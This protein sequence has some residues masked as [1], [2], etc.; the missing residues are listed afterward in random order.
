MNASYF[1]HKLIFTQPAKTS[2]ETLRVR[3]V[4]IIKLEEDGVV[5]MGE[6]A[7]LFGLSKETKQQVIDAL[8]DICSNPAH[9]IEH[10]SE[11]NELPSVKFALESAWLDLQN[12]GKQIYFKS[13]FTESNCSIPING[14]VW[15]GDIEH[16]KNQIED[17]ISRGFACIKLKIGSHNFE[18]ELSIIKQVRK[19]Y[20][21]EQIT[22]RVDANGA[23]AFD[24]AQGKLEQLAKLK[25]HSIEQPIAA[26][27]WSKLSKLC[28]SSPLPIALDEELIGIHKLEDKC[29]LLDLVS[30]QYLILKP[31][32]H[33]G[34]SG[35]DEWISLAEER[36][37]RW[38]VTSYLES[39]I[40][41][42]AIAQWVATKKVSFHQGLGTGL[43]Y[44]NNFDTPLLINGEFLQYSKLKGDI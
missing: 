8:D 37:I 1:K 24:E 40:G 27:N 38:W 14:L 16:M 12:G 26:G 7:P 21:P 3:S 5:G 39:N 34:F 30:P 9:F 29:L 36:G 43:L 2:R 17:K 41:L 25:L 23:F 20:S 6:C 32:L 15:M 10:I 4:W 35:C 33:G 44:T 18:D 22:I 19:L 42:N 11:L 13:S 28:A 31:S